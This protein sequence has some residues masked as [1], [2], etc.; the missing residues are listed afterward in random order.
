MKVPYIYR[1]N[2]I[3]KALGKGE[4]KYKDVKARKLRFCSRLKS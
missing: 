2:G 3:T 1:A 4:R